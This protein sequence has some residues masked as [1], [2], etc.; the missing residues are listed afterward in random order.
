MT[1][2]DI[3][4]LYLNKLITRKEAREVIRELLS[5]EH[6]IILNA[7]IDLT[8]LCNFDYVGVKR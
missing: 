1:V 8:D 5:I 4:S 2:T 6:G 3:V 7:E